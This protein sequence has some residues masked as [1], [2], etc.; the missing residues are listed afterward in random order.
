MKTNNTLKY[1]APPLKPIKNFCKLCGRI[2]T[3]KIIISGNEILIC[4]NCI[5]MK[6]KKVFYNTQAKKYGHHD[7]TT[8]DAIFT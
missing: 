6:G 2:K 8:V 1:K 7:T 3:R 4:N 5:I